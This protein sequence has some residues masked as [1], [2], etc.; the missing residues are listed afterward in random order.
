MQMPPEQSIIDAA[1]WTSTFEEAVWRRP[2]AARDNHHRAATR[3]LK[4][5]GEAS[6][7]FSASGA[8]VRNRCSF[9]AGARPNGCEQILSRSASALSARDRHVVRLAKMIV[10]DCEASKQTAHSLLRFHFQSCSSVG[11]VCFAQTLQLG[12]FLRMFP[13]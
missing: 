4:F 12:H 9:L 7:G 13:D 2:F 5:V 1:V 10:A 6:D 11:R 8:K 3:L